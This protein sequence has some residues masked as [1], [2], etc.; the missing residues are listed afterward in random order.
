M[1]FKLVDRHDPFLKTDFSLHTDSGWE[2]VD[3]PIDQVRQALAIIANVRKISETVWVNKRQCKRV[4]DRYFAISELLNNMSCDKY[5]T[6]G[7]AFGGG[8]SSSNK[9]YPAFDELLT[10]LLKGQSLVSYYEDPKGI[11]IVISRTD[12][13]EAFK[14]I[15]EELDT[16]KAQF[17]FEGLTEVFESTSVQTRINILTA[18]AEADKKEMQEI[19]TNIQELSRTTDMGMDAEKIAHVVLEKNEHAKGS[20]ELPSYLKIN[21]AAIEINSPVREYRRQST[22]DPKEMDGW[23]LV[24]SG[25]WLGCDF[26]VKV[27]KAG[28]VGGAMWNKQ[29]LL[30]EVGCL[31]GL[32][33]PHITRLV[34]F[35]Q[36]NEKSIFLMELMDGDL[37][38][39]MRQKLQFA[40]TPNSRPFNRSEE[41]DII[42]Q[43][44]KGMYY[45]HQQGYVHGDLKCSNLL[46][47]NCDQYLEVKISDLRGSQ[48]LDKEWD[49]VAFKQASLT[50]RPRWTAPEAIAEYGG[51]QPSKESLKK[52]D[53]YSFGMTCYEIVTGKYPFDGIK[54]DHLLKQIE[55][56]FRPELPED[57]DKSLKGLITTCWDK[58]PR[59]R[60]SFENICHLLGVTRS[61]KPP[62]TI[63]SPGKDVLGVFRGISI[64]REAVFGLIGRKRKIQTPE[65]SST[66]EAQE[67]DS[68]HF[69]RSPS[70]LMVP[71]Y[72]R[73]PPGE[74]K[75]VRCIGHGNSAKVYEATWL[76][77]T[78]AVKRFKT[79]SSHRDLQHEVDFLINLSRH[80]CIVQMVGLSVDSKDKCSIVMEYMKGNLHELIYSRMQKKISEATG[81]KIPACD[82]VPF[83]IH[84]AVF[85][86]TRIALGMAYLHF[87]GVMHRDLKPVN[88]LAQ[89]HAG[90]LDVKIVDF[91]ISHLELPSDSSQARGPYMNAGTGFWR[92]PEILPGCDET[93]GKLDLKATDVYSFAITSYEILT[94]ITPF[95]DI[96]R[97]DYHRVREGLRPKLPADLN[98][99]LKELIEQCWHT[100]PLKRPAF[101]EI[102]ERLERIQRML[103]RSTS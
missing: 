99:E 55:E 66:W 70:E 4:A 35:G 63:T 75:K 40:P 90:S 92:A 87:K 84:E 13:R 18:D 43:I 74:L 56:G 39:F 68:T 19:F 6:V 41:L 94:G 5:S 24:F 45:M 25:K 48:K 93:R 38:D 29:Q 51:L 3:E 16:M 62:V 102:C 83:D 78:F 95:L 53:V 79:G 49:P 67:E 14:E 64:V 59:I 73:I 11:S 61:K 1:W 72:L 7:K 50:R 26:A 97:K 46:V 54:D 60:P 88:V 103:P 52:S 47:K 42:T 17:D 23:V 80:P 44:A 27:F 34:G 28:A 82:V 96:K 85:I 101:P 20:D 12:N 81:Q 30:K 65:Q 89:E 21:L 33:H 36:D 71:E 77:C 76:G 57:L 9:D 15:H 86:I 8:S 22:R 37:R 69:R 58:E 98:S 10:V 100:N 2:M 31:E 32:R 91:G